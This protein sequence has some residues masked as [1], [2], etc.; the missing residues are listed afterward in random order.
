MP[1]RTTASAGRT[2]RSWHRREP[3]YAGSF[4]MLSSDSAAQSRLEETRARGRQLMIF[5]VPRFVWRH[6]LDSG[7]IDQCFKLGGAIITLGNHLR[8]VWTTGTYMRAFFIKASWN[9][10]TSERQRSL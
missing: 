8:L 10:R 1:P 6:D 7:R 2:K 9:V 3:H 4:S 5:L